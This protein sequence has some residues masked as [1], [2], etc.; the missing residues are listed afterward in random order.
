[1]WQKCKE[2]KFNFEIF[3]RNAWLVMNLKYSAKSQIF[4]LYSDPMN[5]D[6]SWSSENAKYV[7]VGFQ[8]KNYPVSQNIQ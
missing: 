6:F 4:S 3:Y 1:M 2:A 7:W 5:T 8:K